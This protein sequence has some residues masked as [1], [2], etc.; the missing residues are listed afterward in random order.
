MTDNSD[1]PP[2]LSEKDKQKVIQWVKEKYDQ[3][4]GIVC[5]VC[6]KKKWTIGD[7]LVMPS[8]F[9]DNA[10]Q[11]GGVGYP[12]AM[13]LCNNCGHTIFI[14]AVRVGLIPEVEAQDTDEPASTDED[15][16]EKID[17]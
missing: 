10:V 13:L 6:Q 3:T 11:I 17:G 15:S 14:N 2:S 16:A 1:A 7:D 9:K 5:S 8:V 4:A 12:Q